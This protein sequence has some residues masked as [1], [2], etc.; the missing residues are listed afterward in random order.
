MK[1]ETKEKPVL[2]LVQVE[3]TLNRLAKIAAGFN[4]KHGAPYN[5]AFNSTNVAIVTICYHLNIPHSSD[6]E[7]LIQAALYQGMSVYYTKTGKL[8][9][10]P[11]GQQ[12]VD[13]SGTLFK[14]T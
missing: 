7:R 8:R 5:V 4:W 14:L 9:E 1:E 6:I 2:T 12:E 10:H 3:A 11:F 13:F